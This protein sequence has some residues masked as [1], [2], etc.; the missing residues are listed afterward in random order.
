MNADERRSRAGFAHLRPS[1][2]ICGSPFFLGSPGIAGAWTPR[3][4]GGSGSRRVEWVGVQA[5][6]WRG[7]TPG[8]GVAAVPTKRSWPGSLQPL[9]RP[10]RS[11]FTR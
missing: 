11:A 1:A 7:A 2:F 8:A 3:M 4:P 10:P 5:A 9:A 6:N